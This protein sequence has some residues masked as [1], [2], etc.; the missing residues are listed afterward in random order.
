MRKD[1]GFIITLRQMTCKISFVIIFYLKDFM[2]KCILKDVTMSG[3]EVEKVYNHHIYPR[4]SITVTDKR[5]V[6]IDK[7]SLGG[8]H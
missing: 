7:I 6:N 5:F 4:H 3:S 2:K 8:T 1:L